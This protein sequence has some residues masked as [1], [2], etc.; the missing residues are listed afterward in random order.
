ME[1]T[2][3]SPIFF[4]DRYEHSV[5]DKGRVTLP[6]QYR[7]YFPADSIAYFVPAGHGEPCIRVFP[8]ESWTQYDQKYLEQLNEFEA[9]DVSRMIRNLYSGI[10][11]VTVD[12]A[13]RVLLP[14]AAVKTLGLSGKVLMAGHRDHFEIW[15]P[16]AFE[17]FVQSE[18]EED[19]S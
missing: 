12:K 10:K 2:D 7:R 15:D 5:D 1:A 3:T 11:K 6:A 17:E 13:G 18:C 8:L 4:T 9:K 14:D 16:Q 19:A